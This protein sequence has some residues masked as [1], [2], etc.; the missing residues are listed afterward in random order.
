[1]GAFDL[2]LL[3]GSPEAP[4][5]GH[6]LSSS[7]LLVLT[8]VSLL[9]I[10]SLWR[11]R[12]NKSSTNKWAKASYAIVIMAVF[13]SVSFFLLLL[14]TRPSAGLAAPSSASAASTGTSTGDR[15][16]FTVAASADEGQSLIPWIQ[17]PQAVNPQDVCPGYTA[18]GVKETESGLTA[19]LNLA[20]SPCNVYGNDVANLTL[21]VESQ[22]SGRLHIEIQPR[23]LGPENETWFVLPEILVPR[24]ASAENASLASSDFEFTWSNAPTFAFTVKRKATGDVLFTTN[25]T[26]LVYE[27]QLIEFGS[28]LPEN[29]NLYGLGEVIHGFRLG[30]NLTSKSVRAPLA[31]RAS[32]LTILARDHLRS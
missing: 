2:D 30:N 1:M 9:G 21:K 8:I 22:D 32:V 7:L 26:K 20:G 15:A 27:D 11:V 12:P 16:I 18:S 10:C 6:P 14:V 13:T 4:P 5:P 17:D 29:Y 19:D 3:A 23:Y 28:P 31:G 24:P 25:G